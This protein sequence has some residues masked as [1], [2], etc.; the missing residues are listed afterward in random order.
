MGNTDFTGGKGVFNGSLFTQSGI[1]RGPGASAFKWR[2]NSSC[3]GARAS[4]RRVERW[5]VMGIGGEDSPK[6]LDA[7]PHWCTAGYSCPSIHSEAHM[8]RICLKSEKPAKGGR[9][10]VNCFSNWVDPFL[11]VSQCWS[12]LTPAV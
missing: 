1:G 5:V 11:G 6:G 7:E 2:K 8:L 10:I 12:K 3:R 4:S 9:L